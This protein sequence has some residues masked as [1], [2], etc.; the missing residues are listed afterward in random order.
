MSAVTLAAATPATLRSR[1]LRAAGWLV[2]GNISSQALRL[3]SNLILTRLLAPEAF[4]LV[5][6]VNT[7]Y[8]ALVMFSDLGVWQSVVKSERGLQ[9][10]F[11]GTAWTVQLLRGALL[12]A[13]V[14]LI[15]ATFQ[16][17]AGAGY[18]HSGTVYADARLPPMIAVFA[19]CAL[20]QGLESMKLA[21]TASASDGSKVVAAP[22]PPRTPPP[23]S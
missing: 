14:L 20:L 23:W 5:A 1:M 11:L 8:F 17:S 12:C 22:A 13:V 18:F 6:A 4:G 3:L 21:L 19:L 2:G 15:A 7:L 10:S 9:A 16:L